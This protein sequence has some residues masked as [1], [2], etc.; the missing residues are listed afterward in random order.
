[1]KTITFRPLRR[2]QKTGKV[3]VA[4]YMQWRKVW[5]S[6]YSEFNLVID[7]EYKALPP[8]EYVYNHKGELLF[9]WNHKDV[10]A[11]PKNYADIDSAIKVFGLNRSDFEGEEWK[12]SE[13]LGTGFHWSVKGFD[14]D[15]VPVFSHY[16]QS[17]IADHYKDMNEFEPLTVKMVT[18][19]Y[20]WFLWQLNNSK[21]QIDEKPL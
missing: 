17:Y 11:M 10:E 12:L 7:E 2:I 20:G 4:S 16:S 13:P 3:T 18:Y 15:G 21:L 6:N 9:W 5:T 19:W 1:M 8:A 14:V